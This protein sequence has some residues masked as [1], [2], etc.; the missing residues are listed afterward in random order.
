MND[1]ELLGRHCELAVPCPVN[2]QK[3]AVWPDGGVVTQRTAN[4]QSPGANPH[5]FASFRLCS[6]RGISGGYRSRCELFSRRSSSRSTASRMNSARRCGPAIASMRAIISASNRTWVRFVTSSRLS[7]GRPMRG[8]L[9][10]S[11]IICTSKI[12]RHRL[13]TPVTDIAYIRDIA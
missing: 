1:C 13:L 4:P 7:G 11:E 2:P 6:P 8:S 3:S 9:A 12:K 10:T 5:K